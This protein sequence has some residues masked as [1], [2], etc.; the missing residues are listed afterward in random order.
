M[1]ECLCLGPLWRACLLYTLLVRR[2]RTASVQRVHPGA[3][4]L[5][6]HLGECL[7]CV[8]ALAGPTY[9][10]VAA[11]KRQYKLCDA[12]P[13]WKALPSESI[14]MS[15]ATVHL[16]KCDIIVVLNTANMMQIKNISEVASRVARVAAQS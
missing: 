7:L 6:P 9:I 13:V 11:P 2:E 5:G 3:E 16:L 15:C 10:T 4:C 14:D 1:A 12:Q 8:F